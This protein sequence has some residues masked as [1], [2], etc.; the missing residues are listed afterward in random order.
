M[1]CQN[2]SLRCENLAEEIFFIQKGMKIANKVAQVWK[3]K[4]F[5]NGRSQMEKITYYL[6][7]ALATGI[8]F[9]GCGG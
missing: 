1:G 5:K 6:A 9:A 3:S 8:I 2:M 7:L 4:S